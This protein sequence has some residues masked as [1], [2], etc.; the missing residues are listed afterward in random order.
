M[1]DGPLWFS[2][3][4]AAL[5]GGAVLMAN[6][7]S[8]VV[9]SPLLF[10]H[11]SVDGKGGGLYGVSSTIS[12]SGESVWRQN[13]AGSLGGGLAMV[14]SSTNS[15]SNFSEFTNNTADIGGA[16]GLDLASL[17]LE[18]PALFRGN[19]AS[20]IGGAISAELSDINITSP[21]TWTGNEANTSGGAVFVGAE[22]SFR[23]TSDV[24]CHGNGAAIGGAFSVQNATL[25]VDGSF[26]CTNNSARGSRGGAVFS[27]RSGIRFSG[28]VS[29]YGNEANEG[30]GLFLSRSIVEV[31]DQLRCADNTADANGGALYLGASTLW[32]DDF[33]YFSGNAA[34]ESGGAA[35]VGFESAVNV[36]GD[37]TWTRNSARVGGGVLAFTSNFTVLLG[38]NASFSRNS[39][40]EEGGA[41]TAFSSSAVTVLGGATFTENVANTGGAL[42]VREFST[43][44]LAGTGVTMSGNYAASNGGAMQCESIT[45]LQVEGAQFLSNS[46]GVSGGAVSLV[47]AGTAKTIS[48]EG[49]PTIFTDCLFADN[50]ANDTGG[51]VI[52]SGGFT[53][54]TGA[55]FRNNTAG[56]RA[57]PHTGVASQ[58]AV[59]T[60]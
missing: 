47:S 38:G 8:L 29:L 39:A 18:G 26:N 25:A 59:L 35:F 51:A 31:F 36:G 56:E 43:L 20:A 54:I 19:S 2:N 50:K 24:E 41:L 60:L 13:Q 21:V 7:S 34:T 3:N 12:V 22:S 16:I 45:E 40:S 15:M 14:N 4:S 33:A 46:C 55:D 23:A 28:I 27:E 42:V 5:E 52:V 30:G 10:E 57:L 6:D 44:R 11:N 1:S 37:A 17:L 32:I 48:R 53:S 58:S 9:N 49:D